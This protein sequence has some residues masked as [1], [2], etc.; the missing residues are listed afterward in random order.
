MSTA[1]GPAL[2]LVLLLPVICPA[3]QWTEIS[4]GLVHVTASTNYMWGC[5]SSHQTYRCDRPCTG[6][7]VHYSS[8]VQQV[9]VDDYELWVTEPDYDIYKRPADGTGSWTQISG[10]SKHVSASGSGYVWSVATDNSLWKC[11]KPCS[12]SWIRLETDI[13]F[14]QVDGGPEYL[15]AVSTDNDVYFRPIDGSGK[16]RAIPTKMKHVSAG[17][18]EIFGIDLQGEVHRCKQPCIGNWEKVEFDDG[19]MRQCDASFNGVL[20]I[21]TGGTIYHYPLPL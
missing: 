21:S 3:H 6:N 14:S 18:T 1:I 2:C 20:G 15:Y 7:W 11:K 17:P 5:S 12:G 4:G 16:W 9:D 13:L 8:F 10:K 19:A